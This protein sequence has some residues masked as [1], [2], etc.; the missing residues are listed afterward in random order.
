MLTQ[1]VRYN[2]RVRKIPIKLSAPIDMKSIIALIM[3]KSYLLY[4]CLLRKTNLLLSAELYAKPPR[5]GEP[6]APQEVYCEY[7]LD[8]EKESYP[9]EEQ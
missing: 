2:S 6:N 9:Q 7:L 1:I 5:R 8:L 4:T 3:Q